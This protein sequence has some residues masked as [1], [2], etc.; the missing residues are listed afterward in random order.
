MRIADIK[1]IN[2]IFSDCMTLEIMTPPPYEKSVTVYQPTN[3]DS[4]EYSN[5]SAPRSLGPYN[6]F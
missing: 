2:L 1:V 6:R 3:Q 4:L 5:N